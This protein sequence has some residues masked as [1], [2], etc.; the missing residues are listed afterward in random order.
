VVT[1]SKDKPLISRYEIVA[2]VMIA[3]YIFLLHGLLLRGPFVIKL[4]IYMGCEF[5]SQY[6]QELVN[7]LFSL[8]LV[9]HV[10][11]SIIAGFFSYYGVPFHNLYINGGALTVAILGYIETLSP[12]SIAELPP[13]WLILGAFAGVIP[14]SIAVFLKNNV[15]VIRR[16]TLLGL[17]I[18]IGTATTFFA[19]YLKV[20]F[21]SFASLTIVALLG[22]IA[23]VIYYATRCSGGS[24]IQGI[25]INDIRIIFF[26]LP[27]FSFYFL[28][29]VM[30]RLFYL[31]SFLRI[32]GSVLNAV[33]NLPYMLAVV[34]A[35]ILM[36]RVGRRPISII[37]LTLL[38]LSSIILGLLNIISIN[39]V[40]SFLIIVALIQI[41]YGVIDPYSLI[42]WIDIATKKMVGLISAMG[43]T[44]IVMGLLIGGY[45]IEVSGNVVVVSLII[46]AAL[47]ANTYLVSSLP[48]TLPPDYLEKKAY[49]SYL[50]KAKKI[51]G[52]K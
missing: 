18:A 37:G 13:L 50:R 8:F 46:S 31:V 17:V 10:A 12:N 47:F 20:G 1:T 26:A 39:P 33:V 49:L 43:L 35:G 51:A 36:D 14:I 6:C 34:A 28:G 15:D 38:G 9:G 3:S 41:S 16:G 4:L 32:S 22:S 52:K 42:I 40:I 29:G 25:H 19:T 30:Y 2:M 48:E 5:P 44:S 23:L 7:D 21:S 27:I 11:G 45:I 24:A